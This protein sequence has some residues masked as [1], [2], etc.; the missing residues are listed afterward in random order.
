MIG[1]FMTNWD[2]TNETGHCMADHDRED[3]RFVCDKLNIPFNEV[4]F[5][6]EYWNDV[7]R[8]AY[9]KYTAMFSPLGRC[10]VGREMFMLV[11]M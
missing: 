4:N 1:A 2:L 9:Y 8:W 3:A 10:H 5:V 11:T 7:F 6:K